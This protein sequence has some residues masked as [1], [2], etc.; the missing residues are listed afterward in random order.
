MKNSNEKKIDTLKVFKVIVF[1]YTI[2]IIALLI[3]TVYGWATGKFDTDCTILAA[4]AATY[5]ATAAAYSDMKKKE[6]K[7]EAA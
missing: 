4:S 7:K 3:Q 5:C 6:A 1:I 2:V